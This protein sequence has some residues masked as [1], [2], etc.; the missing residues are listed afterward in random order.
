MKAD[1]FYTENGMVAS[2]DPGWI[3][4]E[5]D[6]LTVIFD[7]VGLK[8]NSN[9]TVGVACHPCWASG[10]CADEAYTRRVTGAG[11]IYKERQR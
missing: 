4:T 6:M 8:T 5:F 11:R 7:Q 2:T 10:V 3:Q 9:K 1:F